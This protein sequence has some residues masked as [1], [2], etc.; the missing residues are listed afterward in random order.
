M[1]GVV[2]AGAGVVASGVGGVVT[3]GVVVAGAEV[4]TSGADGVDTGGVVI[5]GAAGSVTGGAGIVTAGLAFVV[6]GVA[7]TLAEGVL[8]GVAG[9]LAG[10]A[11]LEAPEVEDGTSELDGAL[12]V[13][14]VA[15]GAGAPPPSAALGVVSTG[16]GLV[17]SSVGGRAEVAAGV[18][19]TAVGAAGAGKVVAP[20]GCDDQM[21]LKKP[22]TTIANPKPSG[23]NSSTR[24]LLKAAVRFRLIKLPGEASSSAP[25]YPNEESDETAAN[26]GVGG[27]RSRAERGS[28][29]SDSKYSKQC[30]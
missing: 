27:F 10:A 18:D 28:S 15:A 9:T 6:T 25:T 8:S 11:G 5:A 12:G 30:G 14:V 29:P 24:R 3:D 26:R 7:G 19:A 2:T 17:R 23:A 16:V 20:A 1:T 4:V 22:I 13:T 21:L